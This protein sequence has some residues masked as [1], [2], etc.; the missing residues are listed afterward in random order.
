MA[1][2]CELVSLPDGFVRVAAGAANK[3]FKYVLPHVSEALKTGE[4]VYSAMNASVLVS[5]RENDVLGQGRVC[6][7]GMRTMRTMRI[8]DPV[9]EKTRNFYGIDG[10]KRSLQ[11]M[12]C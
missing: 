5:R 1:I 11:C 3:T 2:F 12:I 4:E 9:F 8:G 6:V 10:R 7:S